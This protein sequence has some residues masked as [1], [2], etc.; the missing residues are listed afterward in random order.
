M[1][2]TS[3]ERAL[4]C[5][6]KLGWCALPSRPLPLALLTVFSADHRNRERR[7]RE[8]GT[9]TIRRTNQGGHT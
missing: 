5:S 3:A 4:H 7:P 6:V 1:T 8:G 9:V 2:V